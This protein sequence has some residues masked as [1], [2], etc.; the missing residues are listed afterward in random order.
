MSK[1]THDELVQRGMYWLRNSMRCQVVLTEKPSRHERPDAVGFS[2]IASIQIEAKVSRRD[3]FKDQKK[4]GRV[5]QW[6]RIAQFCWYL[7][8]PGLVKAEEVP[9][10]WGLLY[11]YP[12]QV[13]KIK[14]PI[15]TPHGKYLLE[16][17]RFQLWGALAGI[18][19]N[20]TKQK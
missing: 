2:S 20:E 9:E 15:P 17:E 10:D 8:P 13:R 14:E 4:R 12:R 1:M 7:V 11:C 3:F 6:G 16:M 19:L 5:N 18:Q